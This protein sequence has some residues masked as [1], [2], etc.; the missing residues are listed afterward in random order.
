MN[1]FSEVR[2]LV[3]GLG[4]DFE[5]F[6]EKNNRAAGTRVRKGMQDLKII[7]QDIRAAVQKMKNEAEAATKAVPA[8][9]APKAKAAAPKAAPA[10]AT[11][12]KK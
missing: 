3:L 2:D 5:K 1:R 8:K 10:K 11:T 6:Y 7:A 9:A 12:K 4:D